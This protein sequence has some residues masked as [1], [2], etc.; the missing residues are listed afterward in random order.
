MSGLTVSVHVRPLQIMHYAEDHLGTNDP[1][2]QQYVNRSI[3]H[4]WSK[5]GDNV[6]NPY[7]RSLIEGMCYLSTAYD[8]NYP[9]SRIIEDIMD[10]VEDIFDGMDEPLLD[11]EISYYFYLFCTVL[12]DYLLEEEEIHELTEHNIQ[13]CVIYRNRI[14]L[15]F[16]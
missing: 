13:M 2:H 7:C 15:T 8:E 14:D 3:V 6:N 1:D 16:Y 5:F 10:E 11:T 4:L 12:Y 9:E